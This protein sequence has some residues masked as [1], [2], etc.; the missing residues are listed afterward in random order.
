VT[1]I[2]SPPRA[3]IPRCFA[4]RPCLPELKTCEF[5]IKL[6]SKEN[7]NGHKKSS[8]SSHYRISYCCV[9]GF[10][11]LGSPE[12]SPETGRSVKMDAGPTHA[13]RQWIKKSFR[14]QKKDCISQ[15]IV[16]TSNRISQA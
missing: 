1:V 10:T 8:R 5:F 7:E 11:S 14:G 6:K 15:S 2:F 16:K 13:R 12:I 9:F 3:G 4:A